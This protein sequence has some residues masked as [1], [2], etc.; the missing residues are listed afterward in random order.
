MKKPRGF[1]H[2]GAVGIAGV[3]LG[4]RGPHVAEIMR[5]HP[6]IPWFELLAD[7]WLA[8]GGVVAAELRNIREVYPLTM[9][10][11]GMSLG[12]TDPLNWD[13]LAQIRDLAARC[14]PAWI[15]DHLSF[16]SVGGRNYHDLL[17]LPYTEQALQHVA[18]RIDRVQNYLRR[19]ILVENVSAY[20]DFDESQV[21]EAQFVA[22]L[23][24]TADCYLLLD[25]NNIHVNAV[26]LGVDPRDYIHR[27]PAERVREI[28]LAGFET[29]QGYLLDAHNNTVAEPVWEL[30]SDW[31]TRSPATPTLIEWDKDIPAFDVLCNEAAKASA[32]RD[33]PFPPSEQAVSA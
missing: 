30:Y 21:S 33:A 1:S 32:L 25:I 29:R 2:A 3:G 8:P 17:P 24:E 5:D 20:L 9:H 12:G 18:E 10:C 4:L 13:Y 22:E 26:N 6:P 14:E 27:M 19:R 15:S 31:L 11:V 28:H 16:S 7:N 23:A